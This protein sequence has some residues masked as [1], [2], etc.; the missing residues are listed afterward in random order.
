[1]WK[2]VSIVFV[3]R[4][5]GPVAPWCNDLIDKQAFRIGI[6]GQYTAHKPRIGSGPPFFNRD[7]SRG[8]EIRPA[9]T[10]SRG[11]AER[12]FNTFAYCRDPE[13][14]AL[15]HIETMRRYILKYALSLT[16]LGEKL[17]ADMDICMPREN[18]DTGFL[19]TFRLSE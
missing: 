2:I 4:I 10:T 17:I 15:W 1:M 5:A 14:L 12:E 3:W 13:L 16:Q 6:R 9:I 18:D 7:L 8:Y 11:G 19:V